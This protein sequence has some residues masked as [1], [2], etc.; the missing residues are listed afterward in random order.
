M[1]LTGSGKKFSEE[2]LAEFRR[3]Y[4]N[5]KLT[6]ARRKYLEII[7]EINNGLENKDKRS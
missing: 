5:E 6:D 1:S 4:L 7:L 2:E 3:R